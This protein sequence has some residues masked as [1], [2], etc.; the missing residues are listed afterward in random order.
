MMNFLTISLLDSK[1]QNY[2]S[3][4]LK[5]LYAKSVSTKEPEFIAYQETNNEVL[6]ITKEDESA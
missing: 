6:S 3:E 1:T 4:I 5:S 2:V